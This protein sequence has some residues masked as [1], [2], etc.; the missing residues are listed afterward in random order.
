MFDVCM[1]FA[2]RPPLPSGANPTVP[3]ANTRRWWSI[4]VQ[5]VLHTVHVT[6]GVDHKTHFAPTTSV[7]RVEEEGEEEEEVLNVFIRA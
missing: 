4:A 3:Y 6:S 2:S 5:L 7:K 1:C